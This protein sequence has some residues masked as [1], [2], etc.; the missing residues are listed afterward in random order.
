MAKPSAARPATPERAAAVE[1]DASRDRAAGAKSKAIAE[2]EKKTIGAL[3]RG[4]GD[5][6]GAGEVQQIRRTEPASVGVGRRVVAVGVRVAPPRSDK[7]FRPLPQRP[8]F[9]PR[10]ARYRA[11]YLPGRGYLE[12]LG[13]EVRKIPA[14]LAAMS[15]AAA[16]PR[17]RTLPPPDKNSLRVAVDLSHKALPIEGGQTVV[18]VRIRSTD[19][20]PARRPPLRLHLV[21]DRS[22]SMKGEPWRQVCA[23]A[24]DLATR[25]TPEDRLSVVVYSDDARV[26]T[27]TLAGG[28]QLAAV[29][30]EICK[31]APRGETYTQAGLALGYQQARLAYDP[32]SVNRVL[33]VSDGMPTIGPNDPYRLTIE[34]A[35]ALGEGITTSALGVGR[36][37]D[38]LLM[39]RIALEGGGNHHFVRD[40]AALPTVLTD[41]LE[42][43][44]HQAAEAVD[45][46]IRL[47]DDMQLLEVIGSE[48]LSE[49]EALRVRQVEVAG[50]Q[51]LQRDQGIAADRQKDR[52]GGVRFLLPTFRAGDEHAFLLRVGVAPGS[53]RREVVRVE[54]RYKDMIAGRN[55]AFVGGRGI[56]QG[57]PGE[58]AEAQADADVLL[59]EAEARAADALQRAS[60]YLDTANLAEI[61]QEL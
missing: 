61:R 15:L 1:A 31:M 45:V 52:D 39:D 34:T 58:T 56:D 19:Q 10:D 13:A 26:L 16:A 50:D 7:V 47:A 18:R 46:R 32:G 9:Y 4:E 53:G 3:D 48:P 55:A 30:A 17:V 27:P 11:N 28:P 22:G 57:V 43:L 20:L 21:L 29:A 49:A 6:V 2:L 54:V 14:Q 41:E 37:F 44:A 38:A 12:R 35:R 40:V 25:L 59:S 24:K 8:L 23:A 33:L 42:V 5:V 51:R 60:E 36:D